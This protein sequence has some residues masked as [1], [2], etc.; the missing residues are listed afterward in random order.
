MHGRRDVD[1]L[2][3]DRGD[4]HPMGSAV[5]PTASVR[6]ELRSAHARRVSNVRDLA[7]VGRDAEQ[8]NVA[9]AFD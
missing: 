4:D 9:A 7:L 3:L 1:V 8:R 2:I 5:A 6:Q